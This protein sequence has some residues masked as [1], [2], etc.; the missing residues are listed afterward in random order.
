MALLAWIALA[1]PVL[2]LQ[3]SPRMLNGGRPYLGLRRNHADTQNVALTDTGFSHRS[4]DWHVNREDFYRRLR[5]CP[6][7]DVSCEHRAYEEEM[8]EDRAVARPH[9]PIVTDSLGRK[10]ALLFVNSSEVVNSGT[11]SLAEP[12]VTL[13]ALFVGS[14]L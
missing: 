6:D 13:I 5:A 2:T 12:I 10:M 3:R 11:G 1:L 8:G 14:V 7:G 4:K 9:Y